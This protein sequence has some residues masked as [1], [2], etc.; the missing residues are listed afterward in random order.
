MK[1]TNPEAIQESEREFIDTINAELDWETIEHILYEKHGFTLQD[2]VEYKDGD[3][4]VHRDQ[5]AYRF[6][7]EIKVPLSVL[8]NRKGECLDIL[9]HHGDGDSEQALEEEAKEAAVPPVDKMVSNIAGMISE[10]NQGDE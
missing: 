7:F 3:L 2:E 1:L 4:I 10:I 6:N 9:T 8:F 5:I